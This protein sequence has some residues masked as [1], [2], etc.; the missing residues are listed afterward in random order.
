MSVRAPSVFM[1]DA[2]A[3]I[4]PDPTEL[5]EEGDSLGIP[6]EIM[7]AELILSIDN[8]WTFG[9]NLAVLMAPDS[10]SLSNGDVDTLISG[11]SFSPM[12]TIKDTLSLNKH[13]FDL[14]N[15]SP[16]WIQPQ[17]RVIPI[18]NE[19]VYFLSTDTLTITIDG[20][21]IAIDLSTLLN[22]E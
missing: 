21:A 20:I 17:L 18:D 1:V 19:P 9:M 22:D 16:N 6:D 8:Q 5:V 13:E 12:T 10:V 3:L 11:F 15:R 2:D 4:S 14:L 7:D